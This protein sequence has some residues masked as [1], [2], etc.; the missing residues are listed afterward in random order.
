MDTATKTD[1]RARRSRSWI[2]AVSGNEL[3]ADVVS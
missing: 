2:D 1:G 3:G